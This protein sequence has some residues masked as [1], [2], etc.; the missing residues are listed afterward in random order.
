MG[1]ERERRR[2]REK[3]IGSEGGRKGRR[4]RERGRVVVVVCVGGRSEGR[5]SG[6]VS[7]LA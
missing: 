2:E 3:E 6:C 5:E 4:K 7:C 1:E